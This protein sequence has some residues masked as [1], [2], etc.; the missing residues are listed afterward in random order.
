MTDQP[1]GAERTEAQSL[2]QSLEQY[3]A[4]LEKTFDLANKDY[5]AQYLE[6]S[7]HQTGIAKT[8]LWVAML[9][10]GLYGSGYTRFRFD[11]EGHF[12][13]YIT[14][15]I[16]IAGAA[17]AFVVCLY[18]IPGRNG[19]REIA[20]PSW[21]ALNHQAYDLAASRNT[22]IYRIFLQD[23]ITAVDEAVAHNLETNTKR[24]KF[25]R[26]TSWLLISSTGSAI[27]CLIY[28]YGCLN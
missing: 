14:F 19:Y 8:Y 28:M 24:A 27:L 20:S 3:Q 15:A 2:A 12:F 26:L 4:C 1:M 10:L 7:K 18:A 11:L 25:L 21:G 13:P 23:L 6:V 22:D 9:L 5:W 17:G 16:A